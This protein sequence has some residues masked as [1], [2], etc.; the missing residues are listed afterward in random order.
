M[1]IIYSRDDGSEYL[2][3][4]PGAP[5][6][7]NNVH[8]EQEQVEFANSEEAAMLV[9]RLAH[10]PAAVAALRSLLPAG[11]GSTRLTSAAALRR[12]ADQLWRGSV[13]VQC[14]RYVRNAYFLENVKGSSAPAAPPPTPRPAQIEE[15]DTFPLTHD[16]LAQ[17]KA[18]KEAA[19]A[20][21][22]FCEECARR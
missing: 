15:L 2:F 3:L 4:R 16:A 18:L 22:P 5:L 14:R 7:R 12:L 6:C 11:A 21:V 1:R 8:E 19:Q 13:I 20:G 9:R 10:N 17:A